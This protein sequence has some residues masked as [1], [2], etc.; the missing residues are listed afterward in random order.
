MKHAIAVLAVCLFGFSPAFAQ[1]QLDAATKEDVQ[2]FLEATGARRNIQVLW[3]NMAQQAASMAAQSY[4]RKH[5]D[6]SP[7]EIRKAA[8]LAG[9]SIQRAIKVLSIDELFDAMVPVY[10]RH[11]TH[12]DI[13]TLVEFYSSPTGQKMIKELPA[14]MA[15]S[16]Q[17][18]QP[19][20]QKHL[21]EL[22]AQAEAAAAEAN[23]QADDQPK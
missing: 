1:Q 6:A 19:I 4:Q 5:P 16:I 22:E 8:E 20:L 17:A 2:Q 3:D 21:P 11:L 10:Q 18:V 9:V 15:E 7:L 14:M 12:S 13:R 23:K